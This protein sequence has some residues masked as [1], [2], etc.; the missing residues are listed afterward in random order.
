MSGHFHLDCFPRINIVR[1]MMKD[2]PRAQPD[3][4]K[5]L[6]SCPI[7][8]SITPPEV[9]I[10]RE[11]V[12]GTREKF[13]YGLCQKCGVL[14][15]MDPPTD[16]GRYYEGYYSLGSPDPQL[17]K[18]AVR[19]LKCGLFSQFFGAFAMGWG[20]RFHNHAFRAIC[21][22]DL[23]AY[24]SSYN[25]GFPLNVCSMF[26]LGLKAQSK[27]LDYGSG[28]G[29]FVSTMSGFGFKNVL[30][31]DPFLKREIVFATGAR[32]VPGDLSTAKQSFGTFDVITMHHV[33]E[34]IPNP[35]E[36]AKQVCTLLNPGGII[37]I[38]FP[39]VGSVHFAKYRGNWAGIHAPRHYFLHSRKSLEMVFT[40]TGAEIYH[41]RGGSEYD[42][43]L[44]SQ[45]YELDIGDASPWSFRAGGRGIFTSSE[46]R[47]WKNKAVL[48]NKALVGDWI[49]YYMKGP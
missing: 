17:V 8:Q 39:H 21:R 35:Y 13:R 23:G 37:V 20:N 46:I 16:M 36:I 49:I 22:D 29:E 4:P 11:M 15:L 44:F 12:L 2:E 43:Y 41:V 10:A 48:L 33:F 34:H 25:C 18:R 28:T 30:G 5:T 14:W 1:L 24:R 42:H 27:I 32:V 6:E 40:G 7:C 31:I 45:E 9:V 3:R 19:M 26:G 38:Q 47:Y